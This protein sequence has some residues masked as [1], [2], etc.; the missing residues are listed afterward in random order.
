MYTYHSPSHS[1]I[2]SVE[3]ILYADNSCEKYRNI[4]TK[5]IK[6]RMVIHLRSRIVD[7]Y[8]LTLCIMGNC[9]VVAC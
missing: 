9:F 4:L 7:M 5:G 6:A 3:N 2:Q 8:F 1:S